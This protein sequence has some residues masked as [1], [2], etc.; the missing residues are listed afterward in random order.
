M[1][2][3]NSQYTIAIVGSPNAILGFKALGVTAFPVANKEEGQKAL[4][5]IKEGK[6]AILLITEDW[7]GQLAEEL[8]A[9]KEL[10]LPAVSV[11]PSQS[12]SQGLG[13]MDLRK[14]VERAVGSD[15]LFKES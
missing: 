9:I 6:Y 5:N 1:A 4:D 15:I 7:A 14:T 3:N 2:E 12:G 13:E 11:L 8:D 10:T